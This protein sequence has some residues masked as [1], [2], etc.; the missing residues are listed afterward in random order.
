MSTST[1]ISIDDLGAKLQRLINLCSYVATFA[2]L[3][4]YCHV[5]PPTVNAWKNDGR[6][7]PHRLARVEELFQ[8]ESGTLNRP[9]K[10]F[11]EITERHPFR[12]FDPWK[13]LQIE[14]CPHSI[15]KI[16]RL[17]SQAAVQDFSSG[18]RMIPEDEPH[19]EPNEYYFHDE[20]VYLQL[21]L[22]E[23]VDWAKHVVVLSIIGNVIH[24]LCPSPLC[25]S[26]ALTEKIT[27]LPNDQNGKVFKIT[28]DGIQ[29]LITVVAAEPWSNEL[30]EKL[31][32][33]AAK[34]RDENLQEFAVETLNRPAKDCAIYRRDYKVFQLPLVQVGDTRKLKL[35]E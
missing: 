7:P 23:A 30:L 21:D 3:A 4:N 9:L 17:K 8:L 13:R 29:S 14:A 25:P 27:C 35:G 20:R 22:H 16:C 33:D 28:L 15:L 5:S 32:R 31:K 11:N 2:E 24:C 10:E 6:L 34:L 1:S 26:T 19:D 18:Y 12:R